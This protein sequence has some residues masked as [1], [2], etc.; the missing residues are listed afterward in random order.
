[1]ALIVA[2]VVAD[3]LGVL[4]VN[5]CDVVLLPFTHT[6]DGTVALVAVR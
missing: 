3:T 5:G 4:K 2:V 6:C 1:V